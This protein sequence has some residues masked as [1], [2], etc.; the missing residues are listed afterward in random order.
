M[1]DLFGEVGGAAAGGE[2]SGDEG[3]DELK[4]RELTAAEKG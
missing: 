3:L 2:T 1:P 4:P